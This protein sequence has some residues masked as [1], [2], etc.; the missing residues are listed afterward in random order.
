MNASAATT[1]RPPRRH[2]FR[3]RLR[4]SGGPCAQA[5]T[6]VQRRGRAQGCNV[7]SAPRF[8]ISI[9]CGASAQ[10]S[11]GQG[12]K[13]DGRVRVSGLSMSHGKAGWSFRHLTRPLGS[14]FVRA[15]YNPT[16]RL[17]GRKR[18]APSLLTS[19]RSREAGCGLP[20]LGAF[21]PGGRKG[22]GSRGL[23]RRR[24]PLP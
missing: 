8:L 19:L 9:P 6:A 12:L 17:S 22:L 18:K 4:L 10:E 1:E 24:R 20:R 16:R 14:A 21:R 13:Q 3:I 5:L 7:A 15:R 23:A 2:C 11:V